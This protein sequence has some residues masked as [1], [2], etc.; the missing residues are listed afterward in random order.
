MENNSICE[1]LA[2]GL[3]PLLKLNNSLTLF[4]KKIILLI[5]KTDEGE[6]CT[7][8]PLVSKTFCITLKICKAKF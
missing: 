5:S 7:T 3:C 6:I 1:G 8:F 4:G 2:T